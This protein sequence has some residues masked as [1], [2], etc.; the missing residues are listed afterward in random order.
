[1]LDLPHRVVLRAVDRGDDDDSPALRDLVATGLVAQR[2]GGGYDLTPAGRIAL[3][4]GAALW[5]RIAWTAFVVGWL[6]ILGDTV[7]GWLT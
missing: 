5:E 7:A 3:D 1:V 6:V 2:D 4:K